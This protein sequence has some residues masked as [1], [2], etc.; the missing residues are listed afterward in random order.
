MD[1][2]PEALVILLRRYTL[3]QGAKVR[4]TAINVPTGG[5]HGSPRQEKMEWV[6]AVCHQGTT[7]RG[8]YVTVAWVREHDQWVEADDSRVTPITR[9]QAEDRAAESGYMFLYRQTTGPSWA[10]IQGMRQWEP[11][12]VT[13]WAL[14]RLPQHPC[15]TLEFATV[16][17][18]PRLKL[19]ERAGTAEVGFASLREGQQVSG[20]LI[21]V[22][23]RVLAGEM[24]TTSGSRV[25][26]HTLGSNRDHLLPTTWL[27]RGDEHNTIGELQDHQYRTAHLITN[28]RPTGNHWIYVKI[29]L[30]R[31]QATI[32]DSMASTR[33]PPMV[34]EGLTR[35]LTRGRT[36]TTSIVS[37]QS[38]Q[39]TN[40]VD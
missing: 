40:G 25:R 29:D 24:G 8:H 28:V 31:G 2:V 19:T 37:G 1:M 35:E 18:T 34:Q 7:E 4:P 38:P 23:L 3:P 6:A 16:K 13:E 21:D 32:Y 14:S 15:T 20:E 12:N 17:G 33:P 27:W 36:P 9:A 30:N 22:F 10:A 26:G 11:W 5:V 39:Q